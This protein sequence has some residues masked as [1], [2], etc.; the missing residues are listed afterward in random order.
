MIHLRYHCKT[1]DKLIL[2]RGEIEVVHKDSAQKS[3]NTYNKIKVTKTE[4]KRKHFP[5]DIRPS[6]IYSIKISHEEIPRTAFARNYYKRGF[7][8]SLCPRP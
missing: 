1:C 6:P 2:K 5:T 8:F 3:C 4:K 7:L